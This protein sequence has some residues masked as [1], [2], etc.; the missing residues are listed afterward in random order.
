[1]KVA[2]AVGD[3]RIQEFV[4]QL[5]LF[6]YTDCSLDFDTSELIQSAFEAVNFGRIF[7]S[8][9]AFDFASKNMVFRFLYSPFYAQNDNWAFSCRSCGKF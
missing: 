3:F 1:M 4:F 9:L 8:L 2:A 6:E 5:I 7:E